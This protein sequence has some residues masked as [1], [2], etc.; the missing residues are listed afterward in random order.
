MPEDVLKDNKFGGFSGAFAV[1]DPVIEELA[2][3]SNNHDDVPV[4]HGDE[5]LPDSES[6]VCPIVWEAVDFF[7]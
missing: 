3:R 5:E 7:Y 4:H 6:G 2:P 1:A